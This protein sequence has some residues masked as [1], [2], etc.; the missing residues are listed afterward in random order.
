MGQP[1]RIDRRNR[2]VEMEKIF[3]FFAW[4]NFENILTFISRA[5]PPTN[6]HTHTYKR[7]SDC[8][9]QACELISC[10]RRWRH[11]DVVR[12]EFRMKLIAWLCWGSS[13][14]GAMT[15]NQSRLQF[16][17]C[18]EPNR[19]TVT[20]IHHNC[21]FLWR[22]NDFSYSKS[23][24]LCMLS[25]LHCWYMLHIRW[26]MACTL[27]VFYRCNAHPDMHSDIFHPLRSVPT[28]M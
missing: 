24:Y 7:G 11:V 10:D 12:R 20:Y 19:M 16:R 5:P 6:T 4:R 17:L 18:C 9:P 22:C 27:D 13:E 25:T 14:R 2:L 26:R 28:G 3:R 15:G 1:V 8:G 23:N 21:R